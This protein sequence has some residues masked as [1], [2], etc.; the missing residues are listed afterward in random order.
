MSYSFSAIE[1]YSIGDLVS[2]VSLSSVNR[3]KTGI[4]LGSYYLDVE[5]RR[6]GYIQIHCISD[7]KIYT[8]PSII[9]K[10]LKKET[11]YCDES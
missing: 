6:I 4:V 9:V 10:I 8:I 1:D 5:E 7:N 2:W 11:T 3:K